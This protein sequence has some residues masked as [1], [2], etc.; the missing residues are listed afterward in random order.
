MRWPPCLRIQGEGERPIAWV[1]SPPQSGRLLK[2]GRSIQYHPCCCLSPGVFNQGRFSQPCPEP[3]LVVPGLPEHLSA[4][5]WG[6]EGNGTQS[7]RYLSDMCFQLNWGTQIVRGQ[8]GR[9]GTPLGL[10]GRNQPCRF[11]LYIY[12]PFGSAFQAFRESGAQLRKGA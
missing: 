10:R 1:Y 4:N 11:S 9:S 6:G 5:H 7:S 12:C 2:E 8:L 3:R